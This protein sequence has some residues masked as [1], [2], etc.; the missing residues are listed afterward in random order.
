MEARAFSEEG[1]RGEACPSSDRL[2]DTSALL[3]KQ[4]VEF[5]SCGN[6]MVVSLRLEMLK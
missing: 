6:K 5:G 2:L 1:S 4:R 3:W